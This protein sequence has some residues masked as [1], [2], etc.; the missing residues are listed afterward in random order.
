MSSRQQIIPVILAGGSG[1]RLW[2]LSRKSYP[3]Q[4]AQLIG[5]ETLFQSTAIRVK[6]SKTLDFDSPIIV[7]NSDSRFIVSKQLQEVSID[8]GAIIIEPEAKNTAAAILVATLYAKSLNPE[9]A[10]LVVSSDQ[11]IP[12]IA[13]F[14]ASIIKGIKI[15]NKGNI[16]TFGITP[17]RPETGYG[18]LELPKK[19]EKEAI[20]VL[21]FVE[22]PK[23]ELAIK[24]IEQGH[25]LWNAGIFFFKVNDL[26]NCFENYGQDILKSITNSLAQATIDLGFIRP[27]KNSWSSAPNISIDYAIMENIKNLWAIPYNGKWTDLG[28]WKTVHTESPQ[29]KNGV[30][31]SNN[32]LAIECKNSLLRSESENQEIV[33]VGLENIFAIAMPDA[34][35]VVH[36]DHSQNIKKVVSALEAKNRPQA[37]LFPKDHRPWGWFE[38]LI[39]EKQFQVKRLHLY[40]FAAI[41]LQ[42]HNH[43]SE[44]WVVVNGTAK[45][46]VNET[47]KFIK[48]GQSVYI[49][50]GAIHRL[51][52]EEK[53]P[54]VVIE[55]QSGSYLGE[56]D[57]VRYEDLYLRS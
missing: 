42:S 56:D 52:N 31:L 17:T 25:F 44:H 9:A 47:V 24:M 49:P 6:S 7:T 8:P 18:Y 53:E 3:K 43:R 50:L 12:D 34:V 33:G 5:N 32:A 20:K 35:L 23:K 38:S 15:I 55:V 46:T 11:L 27:E 14:H 28:D 19:P 51:E 39:I 21:R 30:V 4:F 37:T 22:K 45:V 16:V 48:E 40:S 2:P 57:I 13:D 54:L 1:T 41:S 10:L 29:D 26:L 36:K